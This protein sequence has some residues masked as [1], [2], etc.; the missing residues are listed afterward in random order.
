MDS[1]KIADMDPDFVEHM[2]AFVA[3]LLAPENL[4]VKKV[5]GRELTVR[6]FCE[7]L[8][9]ITRDIRNDKL[10][11]P[12]TLFEATV[13]AANAAVVNECYDMYVCLM[14]ERSKD[15]ADG[16]DTFEDQHKVNYDKVRE[17]FE[18]STNKLGSARAL[19]NAETQ[20][21]SR[22]SN[23]KSNFKATYD[24]R[25]TE[26]RF[27]A[28]LDEV[29]ANLERMRDSALRESEFLS[30]RCSASEELLRTALKLKAELEEELRQARE[31]TAEAE[32][33][34]QEKRTCHIL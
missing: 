25:L 33:K 21:E 29:N 3:D 30:T 5:H 24:A 12:Q 16:S 9:A 31:R 13:N 7:Y 8:R 6:D 17:H 34:Y 14:I 10:P 15:G 22:I 1:F 20:L 26:R 27:Q 32:K 28:A 18:K 2:Q 4:K 11:T 19:S 23:F